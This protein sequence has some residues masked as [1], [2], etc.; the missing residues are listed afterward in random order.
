MNRNEMQVDPR[1]SWSTESKENFTWLPST[2]FNLRYSDP[3][4]TFYMVFGEELQ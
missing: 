3:G 1:Y 4:L 2:E